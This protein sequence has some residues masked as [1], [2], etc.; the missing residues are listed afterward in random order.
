VALD[1]E[2]LG[3]DGVATC[4]DVDR[5]TRPH[6]LAEAVLVGVYERWPRPQPLIRVKARWRRTVQD[7]ANSSCERK[8]HAGR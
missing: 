2:R 1:V 6:V 4:L 7:E 3:L 8:R 5:A